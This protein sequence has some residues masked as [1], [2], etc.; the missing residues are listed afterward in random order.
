MDEKKKRIG[1]PV[2]ILEHPDH[3]TQADTSKSCMELYLR[4]TGIKLSIL[5]YFSCT[6]PWTPLYYSLATPVLE[7]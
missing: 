3:L 5:S 7:L 4:L 2:R 6:Y 1:K